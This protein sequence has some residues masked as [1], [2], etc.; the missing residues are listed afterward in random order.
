[1]YQSKSCVSEHSRDR[2]SNTKRTELIFNAFVLSHAQKSYTEPFKPEILI[3][4]LEH[5]E[6]EVNQIYPTS[7]LRGSHD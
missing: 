2:L 3:K 4:C 1:M 7:D 5:I 6:A